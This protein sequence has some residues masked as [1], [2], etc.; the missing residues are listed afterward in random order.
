MKKI[1]FFIG[2]IFIL[3]VCYSVFGYSE[4]EERFRFVSGTDKNRLYNL[5][6]IG[7]PTPSY[8]DNA[9]VDM[10]QPITVVDGATFRC[11]LKNMPRIIGEFIDIT[12]AGVRPPYN[13]K[14]RASVYAHEKEPM[15]SMKARIFLGKILDNAIK[16][17][18]K[19][20]TRSNKDFR[21][22]ADVIVDGKNI[23]YIITDA[24]FNLINKGQKYNPMPGPS[25]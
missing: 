5:N 9:E 17:E 24:G 1:L 3:L 22:I 2:W 15:R 8:F 13:K 21:I 12:V 16:I 19:F 23:R 18:I 4:Q 20:M 14:I 10:H 7:D 11:S 6:N 25:Y